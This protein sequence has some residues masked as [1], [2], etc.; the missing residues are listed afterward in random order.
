[1][2]LPTVASY[3]GVACAGPDVLPC[4]LRGAATCY[5]IKITKLLRA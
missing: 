3:A 1:V 2:L 5:P 4:W